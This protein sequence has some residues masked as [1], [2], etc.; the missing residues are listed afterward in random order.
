M[1]NPKIYVIIP[2][3]NVNTI[4]GICQEKNSYYLVQGVYNPTGSGNGYV[5]I[6]RYSQYEDTTY[7]HKCLDCKKKIVTR[8]VRSDVIYESGTLNERYDE[9]PNYIK[10]E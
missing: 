8:V 9:W 3:Y 1:S 5:Q 4:S 10:Y 2:V 7:T 6:K